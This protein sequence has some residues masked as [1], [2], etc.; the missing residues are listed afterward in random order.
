MKVSTYYLKETV[1]QSS[2]QGGR[3]GLSTIQPFLKL[4]TG[5]AQISGFQWSGLVFLFSLA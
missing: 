5:P 4:R 2:L 1:S 3:L